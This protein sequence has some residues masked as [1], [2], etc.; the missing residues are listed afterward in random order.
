MTA[1]AAR[2]SLSQRW[3]CFPEPDMHCGCIESVLC[4]S[5]TSSRKNTLLFL[6]VNCD[7]MPLGPD[8][9][10]GEPSS[11]LVLIRPRLLAFMLFC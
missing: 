4:A 9:P 11:E 10:Y 3:V 1:G 2:A 8:N 7:S 6:Q 5:V